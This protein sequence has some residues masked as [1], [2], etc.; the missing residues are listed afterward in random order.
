MKGG[1]CF[2]STGVYRYRL[3]REW[4]ATLP[5]AT[6]VMLNPS[7]ADAERDDPTIRRCT[8]FARGWGFGRL[9]VVNLCAFRARDPRVLFEVDDPVGPANAAHL[10][11][12]TMGAALVLAAWGNHGRRFAGPEVAYPSHHLGFTKSGQPRHPLYVRAETQPAP[13]PGRQS[14]AQTS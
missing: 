3:W 10:E 5:T 8:G 7:A 6:F 9:E 13:W 14:S 11:A 4:D 2:D 1:A 12:A